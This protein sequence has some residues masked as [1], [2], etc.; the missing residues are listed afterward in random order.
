MFRHFTFYDNFADFLGGT[1]W[2]FL[3]QGIAF[4][5]CGILVVLMPKILVVLVSL[6]LI[7]I[8]MFFLFVVWQISKSKVSYHVWG[9]DFWQPFNRFL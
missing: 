9:N 1:W 4:I 3:A 2:M 8:G 5:L 6:I 7:C